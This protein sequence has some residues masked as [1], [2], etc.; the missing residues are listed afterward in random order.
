MKLEP[1]GAR[2]LGAFR[3]FVEQVWKRPKSDAYYRWRY[4][5]APRLSTLVAMHGERC[6]AAICAFERQYHSGQARVACLEPF[7]WFTLPEMRSTAV[8]LRLMKRLQA[9]GMPVLGLGGSPQTLQLLPRL[10]FQTV[11]QATQF[12]LPLTAAY[13]LRNRRLPALARRAVVPV[14]DG[15]AAA[16]FTPARRRCMARFEFRPT[17]RIDAQLAAI[18]GPGGFRSVPEPRFFDWLQDGAAVGAGTGEYLPLV[19]AERGTP[20]AWS[21]GRLYRAGGLCRG[22]ILDV[23]LR[24]GDDELAESTIRGMA[25]LLARSGADDVR[26]LTTSATLCAAYRKAG[27]R[28]GGETAPAMVWTGGRALALD[29]VSMSGIADAAFLPAEDLAPEQP[30]ALAGVA[31]AHAVPEEPPRRIVRRRS[32]VAGPHE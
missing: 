1:L 31:G 7:D 10:G 28:A 12:V 27:F 13:I 20:V 23:R 15:L 2:N 8:G 4:F 14:L 5:E 29:A 25:R 30:V 9:S 16:W 26:A 18:D 3:Q 24:R 22:V 6:V 21:V 19:V 17:P 11:A 32:V